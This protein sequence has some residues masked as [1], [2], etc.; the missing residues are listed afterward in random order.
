MARPRVQM[1][2]PPPL[3]RGRASSVDQTLIK[4]LAESAEQGWASLGETYN[5]KKKASYEASKYKRYVSSGQGD[6][7]VSTRIWDTSGKNDE[8]NGQW[9]WAIHSEPQKG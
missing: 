9:V 3:T 7:K 5:T 4:E 8:E 2:E 6:V 1:V